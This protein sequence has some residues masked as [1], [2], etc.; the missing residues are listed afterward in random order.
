MKAKLAIL[1]VMAVFVFMVNPAKAVIITFDP[2]TPSDIANGGSLAS[3]PGTVTIGAA[4]SYVSG[5]GPLTGIATC[6]PSGAVCDPGGVAV[7]PFAAASAIDHYWLQYNPPIVFSFTSPKSQVVAVA[8]IDHG[9]LPGEALEFIVWGSSDGIALTEQGAITAVFDDGVDG[10]VGAAIVGPGGATNIG[11]SDDFSS[12]WSFNN[13]YS[14]FIVTAGDHILG[15]SS[16]GEG[17][18]DGLAVRLIRVA[19]DI[20]PGSFPNSV[21][22]RSNGKIPVAILTTASFDASTV[23]PT[24]VAFG[25]NGAAP[26]HFALEDV[27]GDG[28]ID[29]ILHFNTQ[30]TGIACGD[31][32]ASL[33]GQ[34]FSGA[35]IE[36]ADSIKTAGCN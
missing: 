27:D 28:D 21:N 8:G 30:D 13:S 17:E 36:G 11:L 19:I 6:F 7:P 2:G 22:P 3:T 33:T 9:P 20:K 5:G 12:V 24:T 18:I 35:A 4:A 32:T 14:F 34:T 25:P 29:M 23:D 10:S 26:V 16:P 15:F 1:S 31:T